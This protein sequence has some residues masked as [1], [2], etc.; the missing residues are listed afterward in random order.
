MAMRVAIAHE[1]LDQRAGSEKVFEALAGCFPNADLYA[2]TV[3]PSVDFDLGGR[4]VS[5]TFLDRS[6]VLRRR[7]AWSLP[8]M[9]LA[10]RMMPEHE[11]DLVLTSSHACVKGFRAGRGTL[12]L[13]Y[14]HTPMRYAWMPEMDVRGHRGAIRRLAESAL[15]RW[16]RNS[17]K[18]VDG[19]AANSKVVAN[20]I[21]RFYDR[22]AAVIYPPVDTSYFSPDLE[23]SRGD[24]VLA[25]SRLIP[26]KRVDIAISA[27]AATNVPLVVAGSGPDDLRLR[28]LAEEIH[29]GGVE[30]QVYPSDE[31]LRALYRGAAALIFPAYEDFGI[32]PVE[33]QACGTPVLALAAGGATET[34]VDGTTGILVP[35]QSA[36]AFTHGLAALLSKRPNLEACVV[37]ASRFSHSRFSREIMQWTADCVAGGSR[38]RGSDEPLGVVDPPGLQRDTA[39]R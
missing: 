38:T 29:P 28:A 18:W 15:R 27:A 11:Y 13:S 20:R 2:M 36:E 14:C 23:T 5:T 34:V 30:F 17:A 4:W 21:R 31:R 6:S 35:E 24:Y 1:W 25:V 32:V 37:N 19:F 10:W 3:E 16:D 9:P 33:A 39:F 26:Y 8:F 7:R 12:H 22:E